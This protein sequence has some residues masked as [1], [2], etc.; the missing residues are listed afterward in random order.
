MKI[1]CGPAKFNFAPLKGDVEVVLFERSKV[2]SQGSVGAAV[3]AR[4]LRQKLDV[5]P[6]AWDF[7][8]IALSVVAADLAG[9]R[10]KSADGWTREFEL[11]IAVADAAFW[12]SQVSIL[13]DLLKFLTTDRW[14]LKFLD[15]GEIPTPDGD[16]VRPPE[17]CVALLSG[18]LDS[19]VGVSDLISSGKRPFAVSQSV[20]GD[21]EK[22]K[23]L[24]S[25]IG[26]GLRH[27]QLNHNAVLPD[28]ENPPSQRARSIVFLAYGI[29]AATTLAKYHK[30]DEIVLYL[31]EN[32]FITINPPL[33]P[34]R[35][36][37]LSTRT[38]HPVVL[39][40]LKKILQAAGLRVRIEN[41]YR[42][43]TKGEML[44]NCQNQALLKAHAHETTSCGRFKRFG[45]R[46][47]GRCIPCLIRRAAFHSCGVT[48]KTE[49]V[50]GDISVDDAERARFDDIRAAAM[51]IEQ[52]RQ[53]GLALPS[54]S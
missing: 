18:G 24:A 41:P 42:H 33:T 26:G 4:I 37:S 52:V 6:R 21:A 22:Q 43:K 32:G 31:C 7:L 49:Y 11:H 40:L 53:D 9:H 2:D 36:G 44:A 48:D 10:D 19:F 23:Q 15:G 14:R 46:H 25:T 54:H 16:P 5:A 28:P 8:S 50:H 29:A 39:A 34:A 20:R 47:C 35:I 27:L 1:I 17:D 3:M 12:S 30:G 38:S 51:A 13:E 45:Y